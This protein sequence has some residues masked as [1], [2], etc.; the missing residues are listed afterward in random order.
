MSLNVVYRDYINKLSLYH[1]AIWECEVTGRQNLTYEQALESERME[2]S[3]VEFKFS[4][5]LRKMMLIRAQFR[6]CVHMSR[7]FKLLILFFV[8]IETVRLDE[9]VDDMINYFKNNYLIGE[10]VQCT[11]NNNEYSMNDNEYA[12]N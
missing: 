8:Y 7:P 1:Q 3:R 5:V 4:E 10:I 6:M 12:Y 9:L 11:L 2:A